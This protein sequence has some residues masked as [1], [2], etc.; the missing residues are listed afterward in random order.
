[1]LDQ[2]FSG[3]NF[4]FVF[5][6]ENRKGNFN[7]SH[8][9]PEYFGKHQEFI[10][11]LKEKL[12]LK[13][14]RTLSKEELD[15]FAE[16]LE[17]INNE[18][19]ELRL[20]IFDSYANIVNS[21][22]FQFNIEYNEIK[23]VYTVENDAT[24]YYAVKQL[25]KNVSKTF[26]VIQ[27][28]RNSIVKQL[29]NI[30]S[31]GFPKVI[32]KTDIKSFYESIPQEKLFEKIEDNTLLSPYSKK[33]IKKLFYEFETKKDTTIIEPKKGIPRGI[34]LSAYLS[35][36]F[37]RDIDS[38]IK[39]L[40]DIV[41]YAR[42]VDDI[43]IIF[44]PK[45]KSTKKNYLEQVKKIVTDNLLELKD[46]SDGEESKTKEIELFI[47]ISKNKQNADKFNFK[48][49]GYQ[50]HISHY[51]KKQIGKTDLKVEISDDKI[52]RYKKRLKKTIA[53]YNNDS[54]YNEKEAR[55][56][57][58]SRL[59][60]LTGNFHLNNNK[61]NVKAGVYY[62]NEMLKLNLVDYNS[63]DNLDKELKDS[64]Q[65][66]APHPKIGIDKANLINHILTKFSFKNGFDNKEKHFYSF[67]FNSRELKFYSKKFGRLT[68][69]FEVIKSI[70][71]S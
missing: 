28:N 42:Y 7:K 6:G 1:M 70:W 58:F 3:S 23:K 27:S 43:V 65:L 24:S 66:I 16:R 14:I 2:S 61:R 46:G 60:F 19:E 53:V 48:Y 47:D 68:N 49:L 71:E 34:G 32:I 40:P 59:K 38:T 67:T 64:I 9:T 50:F 37:M 8:F 21:S 63:L 12:L 13:S 56:M 22:S 44:C 30:L 29:F 69:K 25:Q 11:I 20:A 51:S 41:Y 4:N 26:K 18:K 17:K 57:L 10:T 52:K 39:A 35:E 55:S 15:S 33:L 54:K 36:L 62:S 45:T 5:L 31:D